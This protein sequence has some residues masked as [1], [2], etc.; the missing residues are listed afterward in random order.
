MPDELTDSEKKRLNNLQDQIFDLTFE[1]G[2]QNFYIDALKQELEDEKNDREEI[3]QELEEVKSE[4]DDFMR[5][6]YRKYGD[7]GVDPESG[8]ILS[9]EELGR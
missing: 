9:P 5:E 6:I 4:H 8:E 7:V 3:R 2:R 1:Y